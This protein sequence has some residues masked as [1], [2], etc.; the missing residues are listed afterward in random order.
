M[1]DTQE[2][3]T[4]KLCSF[5]RAYHS[6]HGR[7]KIFDDYLAFDMMGAEEYEEIGQLIEHGYEPKAFNPC[8]RF[9]KE[10]AYREID[11]YFTPIIVSRIAFA[12]GAL[13][14]F[15]KKHGRCQYVICGAGMDTF[16]FRNDNANITIFELDHPDTEKFKQARIRA[17]S[18]NIPKNVHYVSVD[19][20]RDNMIDALLAAGF[21]Q[22]RPS[23]F[24]ILGVSYYLTLPVFTETLSK[25]GSLSGRGNQL[26]FDFP[27]DTTFRA[28]GAERPK[29]LAQITEKLGEEMLHGFSMQEIRQA[30][31]CCGFQIYEHADP[32]EIENKFFKG[33]TDSLS[34]YENIHYILAEKE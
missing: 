9:S 28:E 15:V 16:A 27:D 11:R 20:S 6:N 17:L 23:F 22:K 13:H 5:A 21:D 30:L 12:E 25:I 4:A 2:S 8:K 3:L 34:A 32:E 29:G 7:E 1:I 24:A 26:V 33:R 19:F 10:K 31:G 18:W 14:A